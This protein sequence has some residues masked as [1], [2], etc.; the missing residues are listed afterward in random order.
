[1]R[2]EVTIG[3]AANGGTLAER[4]DRE[5]TARQAHA[6]E[7]IERDPFVR[8][9]VENFDARVVDSSIRPLQ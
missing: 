2:L 1:L 8:E 6:T 9:L 4:E 3:A 7:S 5:R